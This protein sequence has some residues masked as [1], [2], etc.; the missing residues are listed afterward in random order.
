[1]VETIKFEKNW[2]RPK[3][4]AENGWIKNTLNSDKVL[5]NYDWILDEIKRGELKAKNYGKNPAYPYYL[6]SAKEIER[7]RREHQ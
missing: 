7:Y 1:M 4:I 6:V 2:Y 5:S 3:E